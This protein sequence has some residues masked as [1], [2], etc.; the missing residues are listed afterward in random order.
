MYK[1]S[2]EI[3]FIIV[4]LILVC[5]LILMLSNTSRD[6]QELIFQTQSTLTATTTDVS[7]HESV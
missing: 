4:C 7:I 1:Y 2:F 5:T 6:W 3:L